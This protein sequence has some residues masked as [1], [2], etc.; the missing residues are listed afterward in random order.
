MLQRTALVRSGEYNVWSLTWNDVAGTSED[1]F[2]NYLLLESEKKLQL[3][4][5]VKEAVNV[6][7][8]HRLFGDDS[9]GWFTQYLN[10]PDQV[11]WM[12]YAWAYCYAH[13][14]PSLLSDET[15]HF[16]WKEKARQ[17]AG[18][19]F[20]LFYPFDSSVLCGS[21]VCEQWSIH[22]AQDLKQVQT[23]DVSSMKVLLYLDDRLREDGFQKEWN[24]F[25]R[26]LNLMH[27]L[28]G[29][30]VHA[31]TGRELSSE[32]EALC[33]DAVD[34]ANLPEGNEEWNEVL[35]LVHPSLA[36]LCK[37]LRDN[38]SLVPEVGVDIA[39]IDDEVFC[40][41][42]LVW[43]DKKLIVLMNG[44]LNV[45]KILEGMGW[46]VIS[47]SDA[48][49]KPMSLISFLRGGDSL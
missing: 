49:E 31:A 12:N 47:A 48:S 11:T 22:V 44:N 2:E 14:D 1:F 30:V 37:R 6:S 27:F 46:K 45:S 18:D 19:L 35:E 15:G 8:V 9:F 20:P 26:L 16:H 13:L 25:L 7:S 33:R 17:I 24:S 5:G 38:G 10:T 23:M 42:E 43:P 41:G 3:F 36:D 39:D 29:C 4:N 21:S 32:I 28:P 40:T 34:V